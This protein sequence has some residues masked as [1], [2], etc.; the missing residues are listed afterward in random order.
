MNLADLGFTK[1]IQD[2]LND[3][4]KVIQAIVA[5]YI[6]AAIS[7][8][9]TLVASIGAIFLVGG[10]NSSGRIIVMSNLGLA[11]IAVFFLLIGNLITTVGSN[12]IV[13]KVTKVGNGIGLYAEQG[14]KFIALTW[15]TFALMV[16]AV[17]YWIYELLAEKKRGSE[18]INRA[19]GGWGPKSEPAWSE[20]SS[21]LA[22]R[23]NSFPQQ[24][25]PGQGM[26]GG[27]GGGFPPTHAPTGMPVRP[28][29]PMDDIPLEEHNYGRGTH[30]PSPVSPLEQAGYGYPPPRF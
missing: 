9:L 22:S 3:I 25:G 28:V 12:K 13:E 30:E 16:L 26:V 24:Q 1:D 10:P 14:N 29:S 7:I 2:K 21:G 8:G 11:G 17:V 19:I 27:G 23:E 4:P 5:M 15:A 18:A 6:I 20:T